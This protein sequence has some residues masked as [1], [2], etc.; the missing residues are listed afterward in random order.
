MTDDKHLTQQPFARNQVYPAS[1]NT[2]KQQLSN[3]SLQTVQRMSQHAPKFVSNLS[4]AS[5]ASS[6][7]PSTKT[8]LSQVNCN[9]K[10][11]SVHGAGQSDTAVNHITSQEQEQFYQTSPVF[12]QKSAPKKQLHAKELAASE[13][14]RA[15]AVD[16]NSSKQAIGGGEDSSYFHHN[17]H[18]Q[19]VSIS[20]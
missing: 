15:L 6:P 18:K 20:K 11:K 3:G 1:H 10:V 9:F 19:K 12:S 5:H 2:S 4:P 16:L 7:P 14:N 8:V 17:T 13:T